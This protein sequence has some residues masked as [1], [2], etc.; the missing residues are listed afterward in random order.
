MDIS[1]EIS[2]ESKKNDTSITQKIKRI[3]TRKDKNYDKSVATA[4]EAIETNDFDKYYSIYRE[5]RKIWNNATLMKLSEK[6]GK[7][8]LT[9]VIYNE[10]VTYYEINN[11][12]YHA[13]QNKNF[14]MA[15][16]VYEYCKEKNK[17][18]FID[19]FWL[20]YSDG[21]QVETCEKNIYD[22]FSNDKEIFEHLLKYDL[23]TCNQELLVKSLIQN[24]AT[25]AINDLLK[26][27]KELFTTESINKMQLF[28][29]TQYV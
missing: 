22:F 1:Q 17:F 14:N 19:K 20:E 11:I 10:L 27:K 18:S 21:K 23:I 15:D 13:L 24:K 2:N 16:T 12:F 3:F 29:N 25:T 7:S 26:S 28:I 9:Q 8:N 5:Y 4:C 6:L